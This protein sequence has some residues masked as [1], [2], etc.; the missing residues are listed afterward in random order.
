MIPRTMSLAISQVNLLVITAIASG[1]AAGSL[2]IFNFANNLQS[3]PV[4]IFGISF[5][6]AAFP[7]LS[8]HA[9]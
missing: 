4:G 7:L 9:F 2:T 6:I 8:E 5:A 1:L 3:F